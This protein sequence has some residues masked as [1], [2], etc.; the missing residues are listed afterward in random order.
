MSVRKNYH[1]TVG[2]EEEQYCAA[3]CL[4][5][6][7]ANYKRCTSIC[8]KTK[9]GMEKYH[10]SLCGQRIQCW[11]FRKIHDDYYDQRDIG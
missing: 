6:R 8:R 10:A 2:S 7:K 11:W 9:I 4:E 3:K 1:F 5:F